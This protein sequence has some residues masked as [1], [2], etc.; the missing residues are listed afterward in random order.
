VADRSDILRAHPG[1]WL[2]I[3]NGEVI[4]VSIAGPRP[5]AIELRRRNIANATVIYSP[6]PDEPECVGP[7]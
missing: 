3:R 7:G 2:A 1:Q 4:G 5:L 6:R